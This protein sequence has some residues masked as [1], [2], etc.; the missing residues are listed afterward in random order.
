MKNDEELIREIVRGNTYS[1]RILVDRHKDASLN[2][3]TSI[4]REKDQAEDVLQ[5]VFIKVYKNL[6]KFNFKSSFSTW[7]YRIVVNTCYTAVKKNK[8]L[9]NPL[10]EQME[11]QIA[12]EKSG[13]ELVR[14]D[15]R[16]KYINM[17]LKNIRSDE[18]LLL[19]LHYLEEK[20]VKE[21]KEITQMSTSNIKVIL[22]RARKNF[23]TN[24]EIILPDEDKNIL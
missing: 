20:S 6:H 13:F 22:Y 5:E 16:K 14:N 12:V 21:I 3:A 24:L 19:K 17:V 23:K 1:F 11:F 2:L 18:A 4:I 15:E 8:K 7:L 9:F 10:P